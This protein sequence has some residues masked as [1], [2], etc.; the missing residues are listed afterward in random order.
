LTPTLLELAQPSSAHAIFTARELNYFHHFLTSVSHPLPIGN[1]AIWL[2]EIPQLG[3]H[4]K[5]NVF[6]MHSILALGASEFRRVNPEAKIG[7][8]VL[9]HRGL[10]IAGLNEAL[11]DTAAWERTGRADAILAACYSLVKQAAHETDAIQDFDVFIKGAAL[12]TERIR[13]YGT[14]TTLNLAN[15]WPLPRLEVGMDQIAHHV[16]IDKNLFLRGLQ[17]LQDIEDELPVTS[18]MR[19]LL[20]MRSTLELFLTDPVE[21]YLN[22]ITSYGHWYTI[23][24][25]L[26]DAIRTST[27]ATGV[28]LI[29]T[30]FANMVLIKLLI[31]LQ[32]WPDPQAHRLPT[33]TLQQMTDWVTAMEIA[34]PDSVSHHLQWA[35]MIVDMI[36]RPSAKPR[37][38]ITIYDAW[39]RA[40]QDGRATIRSSSP[41]PIDQKVDVLLNLKV[42]AH[43]LVGDIVRLGSELTSWFEDYLV[44][45]YRRSSISKSA[46]NP[47]QQSSAVKRSIPAEVS[48]TDADTRSFI[49]LSKLSGG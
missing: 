48:V 38:P 30:F 15:D 12:V 27:S 11:A 20:A 44:T 24:S 31:P 10:A 21:G 29:A 3:F 9:K 37:K 49:I 22:S 34:L 28:V 5:D 1:D 2:K 6:L 39:T 13:E 32:L 41:L 14:K 18:D 35:R 8:D 17:A 43:M 19:F 36:P 46:T 4:E 26:L 45:N 33:S 16:V 7:F 42:K 40:I 25:G 23:A 47:P